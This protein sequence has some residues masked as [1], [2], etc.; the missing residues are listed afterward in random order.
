[1]AFTALPARPIADISLPPRVAEKSQVHRWAVILS[2]LGGAE[3]RACSLV[4]RTLRYAVYLSAV[5]ILERKYHG[6]RLDSLFQQYSRN[7]SNLWPYLRFRERE[8]IERHQAFSKS[9]LGMFVKS[10][11]F[12]P[13]SAHLWSSPDNERQVE[14]ALRYVLTRMWFAVSVGA[15]GHDPSTWASSRIVDVQE[16]VAGEI[17]QIRTRHGET[18]EMFYVLEATCE[19]IGRP[20]LSGFAGAIDQSTLRADWS[21]YVANRL[22]SSPSARPT[23]LLDH[24]RSENGEDYKWGISKL[25]L[26]RI[27]KEGELGHAKQLVAKR[28]ILANV[29]ANSIS[30]PWM[31]TSAMAQEFA[32]LPRNN[33]I[34]S[35]PKIPSTSLYLPSHHHIES[36]H[37]ATSKNEDLHPALAIVQTPGREYYILKDNGMQVGCEEEG[38]ADVW[39]HILQC[40]SQGRVL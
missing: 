26:D 21:T 19:V 28:Y 22:S 11:S 7:T 18:T 14:V 4:S 23:T 31:S 32:G 3:R 40:D 34:A 1:M 35:R 5:Y 37:F 17:W 13:M 8:V 33:G 12:D 29:V 38:V 16:I 20:V 9:F 25:W 36:V 27:S 30:G 2:E 39:V 6:R 24:I 15:Y 10:P